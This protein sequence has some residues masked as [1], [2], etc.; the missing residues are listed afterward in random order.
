MRISL[1]PHP[2]TPPAAISSVEAEIARVEEGMLVIR[3]A[4]IGDIGNLRIPE[5][6]R[7]STRQDE[8]WQTTCFEAFVKGPGQGV[9]LE[10]NFAPSTG[11]AAYRFASYREQREDLSLPAPH[12]DVAQLL[13]QLEVTVAVDTTRLANLL[14]DD[15]SWLFNLTA[16][17]EEQDGT[18]SYWALAHPPGKPDFHHPDCF[19]LELPPPA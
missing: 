5:P 4:A 15:A 16:V 10:F 18:K 19:T 12:F 11:W 13:D 2:D 17:I 6:V 9:Y 1:L 14:P 3:Y 7:Y 8:L